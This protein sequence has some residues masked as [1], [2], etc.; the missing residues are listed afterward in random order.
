MIQSNSLFLQLAIV[1]GFAAL[2]G[3]GVRLL[4]L[5]LIIAYLLVGVLLASLQ[6][7]D[8]NTSQVLNF[9]PQIGITFALF[10]VGM[11]LDL[12]ELKNLGKAVAIT[13]FLQSVIAFSA[14]FFIATAFGFQAPESVYLG[15]GLSFSSTIVVVKVLLEKKDL[16]SLYGKLSLGILLIEDLVAIIVLMLMA[17]G[18]SSLSLGLQGSL[19]ILLLLGKGA[20]LFIIALVLSRYFLA[21]IFSAMAHSSELLFLS[22][23]AWCFIFVTASTLLG[24]SVVIGAFLAGLALANSPF[25][26]EIQGKVKPLRDFFVTLFF[27]YLGSQVVFSE[28]PKVLPLIVLFVT[29]AV[30]LKPIVFLLILGACG[31]RKHTIFQ[32]AVHL[33]QISEFSLIIIIV[34]LQIGAVSQSALTAMALT[35][36]ISIII[37]SLLINSSKRIYNFLSPVLGFFERKDKAQKM[38]SAQEVIVMEDHVILIGA[39]RMGGEIIK[40]LKKED[41]PF[42]VLDFNPEV[43]DK[44]ALDKVEVIYGDLGDPEILDVLNLEKSKLIIS[45]AANLDDNLMLLSELKRR[46]ARAVTIVR[47]SSAAETESLYKAGADYVILPEIVSGDFVAQVLRSHW[48]NM[49]FFKNRKKIELEKL[50]RN[51]LAFE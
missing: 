12:K 5:P 33:S 35:G 24:F 25:H 19:P 27:V 44:L 42:T 6:L 31:F 21:G 29:Y 22:A 8:I 48:P 45:T 15:I 46:K 2:V 13:S 39:H 26:F 14:G 4:R 20:L 41:V 38:D 23:L 37:S 17:I 9:L 3:F 36:V 10:F 16:S 51:H 30:L 47:G 18:T 1:L 11:E 32:T 43:V 7:F 40:F 28:L 50:A 34:G 49:E